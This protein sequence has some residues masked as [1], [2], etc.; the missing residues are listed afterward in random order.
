VPRSPRDL[1]VRAGDEVRGT[2]SFVQVMASVFRRPSLVAMEVAWR[3]AVGIVALVLIAAENPEAWAH[4]F[5]AEY[6]RQAGTLLLHGNFIVGVN[7]RGLV[8]LAVAVVGWA[9]VSGVARV[10]ILRR[11]DGALH[12]R[13]GTVVVITILR[14]LTFSTLIAAWLWAVASITLTTLTG[15]EPNYVG[16]FAAV[17]VLTLAMCM[18]WSVVSWVFPLAMTLA[19]VRDLGVRKSFRAAWDEGVLRSKIIEINLVMGIVKIALVVLAMVFSATPLPFQAFTTQG[20]LWVWWIAVALLYL[21]ASDFFHVVRLAACLALC[22]A[23][24]AR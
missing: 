21:L 17:V 4:R 3:W 9:A 18:L 7:A 22:R 1:I 10:P 13:R 14:V 12:P 15:S 8:V 6:W 5:D 2:Q 24:D 23:Y 11:L 20:F 16:A 19:M